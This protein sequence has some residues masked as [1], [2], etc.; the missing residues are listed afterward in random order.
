MNEW[1]DYPNSPGYW[2]LGLPGR[3]NVYIA[4]YSESRPQQEDQPEQWLTACGEDFYTRSAF[5]AKYPN[6]MFKKADAPHSPY[7]KTV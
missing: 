6:G 5:Q 1:I 4:I 7:E 3:K 2:W